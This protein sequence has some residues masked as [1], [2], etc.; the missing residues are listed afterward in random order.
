VKFK[1]LL[2]D[3]TTR[4]LSRT[5]IG[6]GTLT[7][8]RKTATVTN[9]T[10]ATQIHQSLDVHCSFTTEITLNRKL[11][12]FLTDTLDIC[13]IQTFDLCGGIKSQLLADF[14]STGA[15]NAID[16]GE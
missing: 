8:E 13:F 10:I 11:S 5:S 1:K 4:T 6:A 7:T 2:T 9:T 15:P 3:G 16:C 14:F 12:D